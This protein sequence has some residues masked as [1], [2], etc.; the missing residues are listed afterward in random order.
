[1]NKIFLP[2]YRNYKK[3]PNNIAIADEN[4]F[5]IR[6]ELSNYPYS[7]AYKFQSLNIKKNDCASIGL[8]QK[9]DEIEM[10]TVKSALNQ[11]N[12][13]NEEINTHLNGRMEGIDF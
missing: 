7:I 1:M 11:M 10:I 2:I 5:F 8:V 12:L 13:L 3:Q 6:Q 4:G 9:D